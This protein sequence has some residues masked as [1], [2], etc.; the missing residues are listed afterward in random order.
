MRLKSSKIKYSS[1]LI[2]VVS[3]FESIKNL[4][5]EKNSS[6][7]L[8]SS[9]KDVL[10]N[11]KEYL[12]VFNKYSFISN[13]T[14]DLFYIIIIFISSLIFSK[15]GYSNIILFSSIFY[16][17]NSLVVDISDILFFN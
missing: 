10:N 9:Y 4:H 6:N 11:N 14:A 12:N 7:K 5:S 1:K 13:F 8:Y 3:S 17:I 16:T 2:D 15:S